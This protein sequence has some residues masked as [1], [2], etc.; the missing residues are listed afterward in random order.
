MK[1]AKSFFAFLL[2]TRI[3]RH[4]NTCVPVKV[5]FLLKSQILVPGIIFMMIG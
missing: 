3:Q 1:T 2:Y 4:F 5:K